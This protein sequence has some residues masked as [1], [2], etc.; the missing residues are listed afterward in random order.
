MKAGAGRKISILAATLL[1]SACGGGGGGSVSPPGSAVITFTSWRD[2]V[3]GKTIEVKGGGKQVSYDY[4][5]GAI[6]K[7]TEQGYGAVTAYFTFD[8]GS[9][10]TH[11]TLASSVTEADFGG[12]QI[13]TLSKDNDF[14]TAKSSSGE[15]I[16][17]NPASTYWDYQSFG[18]WET[19][20]DTPSGGEYGAM[21][22]GRTTADMD[23]PTTNSA[24][25]TGKVVGSYVDIA[26]QGHTALADLSVGVNWGTQSMTFDTTNTEISS[27]WSSAPFTP[28]PELDITGTMT[29]APG[30]NG[31]TSND[32]STT[33]GL[34]GGST[35]QFYG[36]NAEELGGV[37]LL[38]DP[39]N[40]NSVETY[41][42]AYGASLVPAP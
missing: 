22:V 5:A 9:N 29:Y 33:S 38:R 26:G 20:L 6:S 41:S 37:F 19:G 30:T 31:F 32:L 17:S 36:P 42:G 8:A 13:S 14:V 23:I 21:S 25:F 12:G 35:G 27:N 11:L 28:K 18:V 40:I 34:T 4:Q 10:L 24:T 39:T 16:I 2:D 15:A 7:V 3:A 1:L